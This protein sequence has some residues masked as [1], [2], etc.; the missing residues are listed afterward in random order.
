MISLVN[1]FEALT[2]GVPD[3]SQA[4]SLGGTM[5]RYWGNK[6]GMYTGGQVKGVRDNE[7]NAQAAAAAKKL[8]KQ[9]ADFEA[10]H[11]QEALKKA[12]Q[13]TKDASGEMSGTEA[14]GHA[15]NKGAHAVGDAAGGFGSKAMEFAGEHPAAAMGAAAL[16]AGYLLAR[17][18]R[19][20]P[21]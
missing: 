12:A 4:Q 16:G 5:A 20:Q 2:T 14:A 17:R 6:F 3:P 13:A 21:A 19:N 1:F 18:N 9:K 11:H 7:A 15:L 8:A 10:A